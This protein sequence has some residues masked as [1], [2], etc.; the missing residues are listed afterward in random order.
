MKFFKGLGIVIIA[1]VVIYFIL[2]LLGP[3]SYYVERTREINAPAHIVWEQVS[4]FKNWE[5]WSPWIEKDPTVKNT[6][7]GNLG[8]VGS[9]MSWI[10]DEDLSGT[11][12]MEIISANPNK[13][14]NYNLSFIVPFEMNSTGGMTMTSEGDKTTVK[15][16]DK[17]DF[18]FLSRPFMLFMNLDEKI[19]PDFE[20]GLERID[21]VSQELSKAKELVI[22]ETLFPSNNYVAIRHKTTMTEAMNPDFYATNF[23]QLGM[24]V[25]ETNS[26]LSGMPSAIYYSWNEVD[27]TT[28]IALAFPLE[29]LTQVTKQGYELISLKEQK[30]V[31]ARSYGSY[32]DTYK[33]HI[34]MEEYVKEKG[35]KIGLTIEEYANDPASVSHPS[36]ILTNIYYLIE[37]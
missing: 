26:K 32:E 10:G 11:G 5:K 18:S 16:F 6:Y 31:L 23:Q 3:K 24:Y 30:A 28:E 27:S 36:E 22:I 35:L 33:A 21:S 20:R 9:V 19:G 15:W 17:G 14:I 12:S 4:N 2:A 29:N 37:E 1:L 34:K 7:K 8:E 13:E 25:G